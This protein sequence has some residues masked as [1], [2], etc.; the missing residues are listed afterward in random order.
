[1]IDQL[2][3]LLSDEQRS[4]LQE[5]MLTIYLRNVSF[6]VIRW[7]C[8]ASIILIVV[9]YWFHFIEGREI[10]SYITW[11]VIVSFFLAW[12]ALGV[13]YSSFVHHWP[14]LTSAI[15]FGGVAFFTGYLLVPLDDPSGGL[16]ALIY[17]IPLY[18]I[19]TPARLLKRILITGCCFL[20]VVGGFITG[21]WS[22]GILQTVTFLVACMAA[23]SIII[24]HTC[25]YKLNRENFFNQRRLEQQ[26][27][28]IERLARYDQL[29]GLYERHIFEERLEEEFERAGRHDHPLTLLMIDIDRFKAVN[30]TYGHTAG[31]RVLETFGSIL[32]NIDRNNLRRSDVSCRFGGEEFCVLLP[33]SDSEDGEVVADRIRKTLSEQTFGDEP[34]ETF[35]VTCSI[36]VAERSEAMDHHEALVRKADQ[37]L[38][39]AKESGRDRTVS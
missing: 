33:E 31:D 18:T 3:D 22:P 9:S 7:I 17:F 35:Q 12:I 15:V 5:N 32:S 13:T 38:Y 34:G 14:N 26:Q 6:W 36:G 10:V 1:M 16:Q 28:Q 11:Q 23:L 24:G 30:D 21:A 29:T 19:I 39:E 2:T 25:F 4:P 37:N 20:A 8:P 27:Q